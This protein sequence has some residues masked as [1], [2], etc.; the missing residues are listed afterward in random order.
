MFHVA[1]KVRLKTGGPEMVVQKVQDDRVQ[2]FW[3]TRNLLRCEWFV[4]AD[5]LPAGASAAHAK[6]TP[7]RPESMVELVESQRR[8]VVSGRAAGL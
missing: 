8:H 4:A 6:A 2:A 3:F 7:A 1:E 5:L